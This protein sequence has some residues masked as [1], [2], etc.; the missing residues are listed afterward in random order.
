MFVPITILLVALFMNFEMF[1][2]GAVGIFYT[3]NC[4][5]SYHTET[6]Y[7]DTQ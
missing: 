2:D 6:G 4:Y 3:H 5:G 1:G 7:S